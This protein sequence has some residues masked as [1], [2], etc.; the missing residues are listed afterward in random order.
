[1]RHYSQLALEQR[2]GI[3]S[4]CQRSFKSLPISVVEKFTILFYSGNFPRNLKLFPLMF[5]T[6][7]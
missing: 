7:L 1:M 6:T 2:Y 5:I 4:L 3:Y